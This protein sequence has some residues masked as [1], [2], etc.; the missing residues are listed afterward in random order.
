VQT[1]ESVAYA[2]G[3][4]LKSINDFFSSALGGGF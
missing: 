1:P 2:S 3:N 4:P